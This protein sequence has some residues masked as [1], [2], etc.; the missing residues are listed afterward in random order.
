MS[1]KRRNAVCTMLLSGLYVV[2]SIGN[3]NVPKVQRTDL[4]CRDGCDQMQKR[5]GPRADRRG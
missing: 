3:N 1:I 4:L 2:G 5:H